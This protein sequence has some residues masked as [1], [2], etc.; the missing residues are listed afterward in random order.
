M[1]FNKRLEIFKYVWSAILLYLIL[2]VMYSFEVKTYGLVSV[3]VPTIFAY[4]LDSTEKNKV[5]INRNKLKYSLLFCLLSLSLSLSYSFDHLLA[6]NLN[7][8]KNNNDPE[9]Y[10]EAISFIRNEEHDEIGSH[11]LPESYMSLDTTNS[12]RY[13]T[14]SQLE[15]DLNGNYTVTQLLEEANEIDLLLKK[16][17]T[18][19]NYKKPLY[20]N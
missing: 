18:V 3:V 20:Q 12:V 1:K 17:S 10:L 6:K 8:A 9:D 7:L 15:D 2:L 16:D 14:P 11:Y 5:D 4:I 19:G 13:I